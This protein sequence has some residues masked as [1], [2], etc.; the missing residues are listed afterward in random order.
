MTLRTLFSNTPAPPPEMTSEHVRRSERRRVLEQVLQQYV[1]LQQAVETAQGDFDYQDREVRRALLNP[2]GEFVDYRAEDERRRSLKITVD[3]AKAELAQFER[4]NDVDSAHAELKT[5]AADEDAEEMTAARQ[6]LIRLMMDFGAQI[7]Q[8]GAVRWT[9][10]AQLGDE[11]ESR[12]P[13]QR[14]TSDLPHIPP[15]FFTTGGG[16]RSVPIWFHEVMCLAAPE[17]F[18][19][20]DSTRLK[21][22]RMKAER[23][24]VIWNPLPLEW[25]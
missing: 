9:A 13:G 10:I 4:V 24:I 8:P 18:P 17:S 14:L 19:A 25:R 20:D 1:R 12:W 2:S 5:I 11:I 16:L 22:E 3:E 15:G 7:L 6:E 23:R 21:I